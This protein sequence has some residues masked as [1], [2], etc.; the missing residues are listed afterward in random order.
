MDAGNV[1]FFF[2]V[3]RNDS[4]THCCGSTQPSHDIQGDL[5]EIVFREIEFKD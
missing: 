3:F 5:T 1:A 2:S 4:E